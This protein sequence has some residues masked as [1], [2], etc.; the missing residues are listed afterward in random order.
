MRHTS[1][2]TVFFTVVLLAGCGRTTPS[3]EAPPAAAATVPATPRKAAPVETMTVLR[4]AEALIT[5]LAGPSAPVVLD[6]RDRA[7]FDRGHI[8]G[9][10]W[11][12]AYR[13]R[14][15]PTAKRPGTIVVTDGAGGRAKEEADRTGLTLLLGGMAAWCRANGPVTGSCAGAGEVPP[16]VAWASCACRDRVVVV[17]EKTELLPTAEVARDVAGLR[18]IVGRT[19][20]TTLLLVATDNADLGRLRKAAGAVNAH[21]L[22]VRGGLAGIEALARRQTAMAQRRQVVSATR[23]SRDPGV[24]AALTVP[25]GC[26]CL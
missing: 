4:E 24:R 8:P 25:K 6:A 17:S 10:Q 14:F 2:M 16:R 9:A 5:A 18:E 11:V 12:P 13:L 3:V 22:F 15:H 7:A 1:L 21:A 20:A 19:G 23:G 26:G